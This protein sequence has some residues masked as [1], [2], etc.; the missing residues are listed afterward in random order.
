MKQT[1]RN[2]GVPRR[3]QVTPTIRGTIPPSRYLADVGDFWPNSTMPAAGRGT[4]EGRPAP[5]GNGKNI[6]ALRGMGRG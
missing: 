2:Q 1:G 4:G 3:L 6:P 5:L